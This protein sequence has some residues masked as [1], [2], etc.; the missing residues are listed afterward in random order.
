MTDREIF[1]TI[2]GGG[3]FSLLIAIIS[4]LS[5]D[6]TCYSDGPPC[7]SGIPIAW[8][9]IGLA[10]MIGAVAMAIYGQRAKNQSASGGGDQLRDDRHD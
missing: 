6:A 4:I 10:L 7:K 5:G 8:A 1:L 3:G 9:L 2:L